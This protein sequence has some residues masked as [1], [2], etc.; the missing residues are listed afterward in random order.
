MPLILAAI[1]GYLLVAYRLRALFTVWPI[2]LMATT[3]AHMLIFIIGK[4][5]AWL[6]SQPL[7]M[8]L[9]ALA[10]IECFWLLTARMHPREQHWLFICL[11]S[12][13]ALCI[14]LVFQSYGA[15]DLVAA[16][17]IKRDLN[18]GMS[19]FMLFANLYLIG[20]PFASPLA[21]WLR[22]HSW[23]LTCFLS[24]YAISG[25]LPTTSQSDAASWV[26]EIALMILW[27]ILVRPPSLC[28][29]PAI[30]AS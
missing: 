11:I 21:P 27:L 14:I 25:F 24:R 9:R 19:A 7:L 22:A 3:A 5:D 12:I 23:L 15:M 4:P 8:W 18:V 20:R 10:V 2:Y 26:A 1:L 17:R 13:S 30:R 29:A 16:I 6:Y 28:C